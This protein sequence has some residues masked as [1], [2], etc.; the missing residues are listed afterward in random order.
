MHIRIL[1]IKKDTNEYAE[2]ISLWHEVFSDDETFIDDFYR[3]TNATCYVLEVEGSIRSC[4]SLY[5]AGTMAVCDASEGITS[6]DVFVSYAI[7]TAPDSRGKGYA[8]TLVTY[9]R[10]A[11]LNRRGLSLICPAEPSLVDFYSQ[12]GYRPHFYSATKCEDTDDSISVHAEP[13][14]FEKYGRYREHFLA[15]QPHISLNRNALEFAEY[16]SFGEKGLYLINGGDAICVL[17]DFENGELTITELIIDPMLLSRSSE[18]DLQIAAGI[19]SQF[20]ADTVR[21]RKPAEKIFT[22]L[23]GNRL[24]EDMYIQGMIAGA[25]DSSDSQYYPYYGFPM[26]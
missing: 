20:G 1:D 21:Y 11:V 4:L 12:L 23:N 22:I 15:D 8:G 25:D 14:D 10:D 2:V 16:N 5:P 9:V 17:E 24:P 18:V 19:A 3:L 13:I 26:D 7:L 6:K